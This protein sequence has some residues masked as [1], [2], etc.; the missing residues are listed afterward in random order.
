MKEFKKHDLETWN[1][2]E[3]DRL[4][5]LAI[6]KLRGKGAPK[7]KREKDR[8][9]R[10]RCFNRGDTNELL[11]SRKARGSEALESA[12]A[13]HL[14]ISTT[15]CTIHRYSNTF[16]TRHPHLRPFSRAPAL[17]HYPEV[18]ALGPKSQQFPFDLCPNWLLLSTISWLRNSAE[19]NRFTSS[20][21]YC[22]RI[23]GPPASGMLP[24]IS[25]PAPSIVFPAC[26]Q[27]LTHY[28]QCLS[29][30]LS[31]VLLVAH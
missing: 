21:W 16:Q 10:Y 7:K 20:Q 15:R 29:S 13:Q 14:T 4:E 8:K 25:H 3:E 27:L 31:V 9:T 12:G 17:W 22:S 23:A 24:R 18:V 26:V 28:L 1:E 19:R 2:E 6:T 11:Q 5:L 30:C